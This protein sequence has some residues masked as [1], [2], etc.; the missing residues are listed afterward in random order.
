MT[1]EQYAL[2]E[3]YM[4]SCMSDS[5]HD[6]QHVYRVLY[7]ALDIA[8]DEHGV[9]MDVLITACL[10]HDIARKE[11]LINPAVCHA[12]AGAQKAYVFL[13]ENGFAEA[14]AERVKHCIAVHRF[15]KSSPPESKEA[16]ILFDA[17]K[18]DAAGAVGVARTLMYKGTVGEPLYN[19]HSDG[20]VSDGESDKLPSF[21]QEYRFKLQKIYDGFYTE[22]GKRLALQRKIAAED[23]YRS[24]CREVNVSNNSGR[25]TLEKILK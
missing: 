21:F 9:D 13:V 6:R 15:R 11:Q 1:R 2:I 3:D 24:L 7:T 17:D 23:F 14:F 12:Q 4:I 25:S 18:L 10:L 8:S 16:K 20:S 5:A 22:R 19:V